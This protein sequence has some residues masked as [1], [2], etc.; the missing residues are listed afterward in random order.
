[1]KSARYK[2]GFKAIAG[3]EVAE[4]VA[5]EETTEETAEGVTEE[6]TAQISKLLRAFNEDVEKTR[7]KVLRRLSEMTTQNECVKV[8]SIVRKQLDKNNGA[9]VSVTDKG[10]GK[11]VVDGEE[12]AIDKNVTM[13]V[14]LNV[15]DMIPAFCRNEPTTTIEPKVDVWFFGTTE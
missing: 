12:I 3:E 7:Q 14:M 8:L 11:Y 5:T 6:E 10:Y 4:E 9:K 13:A 15:I 2:K 1:M